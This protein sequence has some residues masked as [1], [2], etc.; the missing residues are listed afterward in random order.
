MNEPIEIAQE[1]ARRNH[2]QII[3][4]L[5]KSLAQREDKFFQRIS[6]HKGNALTKLRVVYEFMDELYAFVSKF[7]PCKKGC[8][9]C[10]Y[11]PVSISELEID[12]IESTSHFKR[13]KMPKPESNFHG[14]PC[15]FLND[16]ACSIYQIR[17]F[18][19]R[20]HVALTKTAT[21]CHPDQCNSEELILLKFSE[22]GKSYVSI[23]NEVGK[24]SRFDI[25]Q[26][27]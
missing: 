22:V 27:F 18:V 9:F 7:T 21:W 11:Y 23:I 5:P 14:K 15:P 17:P 2:E 3:R 12:Y 16:G 19:C 26:V 4:Q 24:A 13:L 10:C 6:D 20:Q 1:N 25:R 8:N